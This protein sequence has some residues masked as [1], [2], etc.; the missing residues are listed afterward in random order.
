MTAEDLREPES[1]E[2]VAGALRGVPRLGAPPARRALDSFR[3][4]EDYAEIGARARR[5]AP[6]ALRGRASS[7]RAQIEAALERP[8]ARRRSPATTTCWP[9]NFIR[10]DERLW[11]VDWEYAGMGDRYFDLGNFAVNNEL[12]EADEEALLDA[13]FGEPPTAARL[14][15]AA[16][17]ALHVRLP[18]GDVGRRPER[19][20]RPRLRLRRLRRRSTSSGCER[21]RRGPRASSAGSRRPRWRSS[22]E[23][24]DSRPLRDHR[25][26]RRRHLDRLPPGGARLG[27]RRPASTATSSPPARPST[28]P[29][30]SASCAARSR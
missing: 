9:A 20:L 28:P 15:A 16:A 13:Y 29:G 4:V 6:A 24:P 26:R 30:S 2:P 27:R 12:D 8:R 21:D 22:A 19:R 1:L 5:P 7:A 3:I 10:G 14:R 17:D 25:R 18:R 11:I 23:L